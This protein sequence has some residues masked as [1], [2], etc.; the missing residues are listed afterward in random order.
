MGD[1]K[2]AK[3]L[4]NLARQDVAAMLA[5]KDAKDIA[6]STFGFHA[7]QAVEKALKA[8]LSMLDVPYPYTH[9][10]EALLGLLEDE[11]GADKVSQLRDFDLLD[12]FAIQFRYVPHDDSE[13]LD[14]D[15]ILREVDKL[16]VHIQKVIDSGQ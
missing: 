11:V 9:S 15:G 13:P 6:D 7:Q 5:L 8:W 12:P 10:L 1:T 14:R 2:N 4:L 16:L 3:M